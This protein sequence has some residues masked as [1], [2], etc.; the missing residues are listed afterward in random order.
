MKKIALLI[1]PGAELL[2]IA[3]F[4]DVFGWGKTLKKTDIEVVSIGFSKE[5]KCCWNITIAPQLCLDE[6]IDFGNFVEKFSGVIIPGGFGSSGYF[7]NIQNPLLK[8]LL[9]HFVNQD[10]IILGVCTASLIL[11][12]LGFLKDRRATTYLSEN[13]R[14]FSQLEKLGAL[15]VYEEM[16]QDKNI[17]T[18][19]SPASALK[20][21]FFLLELLA[22]KDSSL[23]IKKEMGFEF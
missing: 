13:R 7:K 1:L 12:E 17:I 22:G 6:G 3:P 5:I 8:K 4:T 11:G 15:P 10:K 23:V 20:S 21:A 9:Q 14:Y 18:T 16:V 19:S 2:E